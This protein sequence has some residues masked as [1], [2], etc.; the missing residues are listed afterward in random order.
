MAGLFTISRTTILSSLLALALS[1]PG[2]TPAESPEEREFTHAR[3][4]YTFHFPFD[5]GSHDGFQ[6]EWWY[7]TGHLKVHTGR[8]FGYQLT[9]F[10]RAVRQAGA[11]AAHLNVWV[12]DWHAAMQGETHLLRARNEGIAVVLN[13]TPEKQPIVHG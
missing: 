4:G 9:F 2:T 13:L 10:R 12:A 1:V 11:D 5:H 8:T 7:Y 3:P 6:T